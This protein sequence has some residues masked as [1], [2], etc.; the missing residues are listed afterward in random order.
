MCA[1]H[2]GLSFYSSLLAT[3]ERTDLLALLCVMFLV[4]FIAF[5]CGFLGGSG[6]TFELSI[7]VFMPSSLLRCGFW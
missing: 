6:V 5:S 7:P 1:C 2:T 4:C 3:L